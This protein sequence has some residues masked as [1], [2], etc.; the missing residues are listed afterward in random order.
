MGNGIS[1][2]FYPDNPNRRARAEQLKTDIDS[3]CQEFKEVER[4]RYVVS[5]L[6][7]SY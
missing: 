7:R 6:F 3:F 4:S 2:I 1:N 5:P